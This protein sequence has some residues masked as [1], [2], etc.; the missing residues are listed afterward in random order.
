[1]ESA[2][3]TGRVFQPE[4][5][6]K[7]FL[8]DKVAV[9]GMAEV[10][11]AKTF[12]HGG[13]EKLL[14]IKRILQHLGDNGEFVEMFI[15]EAKISVMLQHP[16]IVQIYDFGKCRENYFI[17]MECVEGKDL[18]IILRKLAERRKLL[19][20]E[21][22]VYLAHE[23]CKGLD[24]AHKKK[25]IKGEP[26]GIVHRDMSPSN[27][28]VSYNGEVKIADFGIAKAEISI[29]NTKDGVLKGKFEYMAPEQASGLPVDQRADL[30]AVGIM[31]HEMLTG[32]RLFKSESE[33]RTLERIKAADA[34]PPSATNPSIPARLDEIVMRALSRDPKD[35]YQDAKELQTDLL[36]FMYPATP[37]LTRESLAHFMQQLFITEIAEER[38]RLEEGTKVAVALAAEAP[39]LEIDETW[40]E[41]GSGQTLRPSTSRVPVIVAALAVLLAGGVALYLILRP[42]EEKVVEKL[43]EVAAPKPTTGTLDIR[44]TPAVAATISLRGVEIGK[45]PNLNYE[46][47]EPGEG[48][49]LRVEAEGYQP[50]EDTIKL[51]A[52]DR[53]RFPITLKPIVVSAPSTPSTTPATGGTPRDGGR[54]ATPSTPTATRAEIPEAP[55]NISVNVS[56][57]WAEVYIDG[58]KIETTPLANFA[59]SAGAHTVR[60]VNPGTGFEATR[61]V[62]IQPGK[63]EKVF[64]PVE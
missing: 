21:Y 26:M 60:V 10:F 22:A 32:R 64:F 41:G 48:I 57:G 2:T 45:G 33:I 4:T 23:V 28:I 25:N 12:S 40:Q 6:G 37:D 38:D 56:K 16:N 5:F 20:V 30:F 8:I 31:L 44:I 1:M 24:Y 63:T 29:Y 18:K 14:V 58:K 52:G 59:L 62:R 46:N 17:A 35:R 39:E 36:E 50:F 3:T 53:L 34:K 47:V 9:G 42:P 51:D 7:Y 11:R 54:S 19:P 61:Q 15:D 27:M 13:F 43:V 55:G 49:V